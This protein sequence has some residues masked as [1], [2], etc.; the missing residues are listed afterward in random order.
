MKPRY[1]AEKDILKLASRAEKTLVSVLWQWT[2]A[3][4]Y[5]IVFSQRGNRGAVVKLFRKLVNEAWKADLNFVP[6]PFELESKSLPPHQRVEIE[7]KQAALKEQQVCPRRSL[8][9]SSIPWLILCLGE[10]AVF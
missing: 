2:S 7:E 4:S 10:A 9:P 3:F 5:I 6:A 1:D 8:Q